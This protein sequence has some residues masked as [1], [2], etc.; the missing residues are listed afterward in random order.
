MVS[1]S[2]ENIC[3][4][5]ERVLHLCA[6]KQVARTEQE[7]LNQIKEKEIHVTQLKRKLEQVKVSF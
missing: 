7:I 5:S 4:Q 3:S 1:A 6:Q 2:N